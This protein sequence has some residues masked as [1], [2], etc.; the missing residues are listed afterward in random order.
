MNN[1]ENLKARLS[2]QWNRPKVKNLRRKDEKIVDR[3]LPRDYVLIKRLQGEISEL[4]NA[5]HNK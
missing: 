3:R 4:K 5:I 2:K 1:L